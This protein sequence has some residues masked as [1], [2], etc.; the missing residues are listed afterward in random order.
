MCT[1]CR[2]VPGETVSI[3]KG[4][5]ASIQHVQSNSWAMAQRLVLSEAVKKELKYVL[6]NFLVFHMERRLRAAKYLS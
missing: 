5:V 4:A 3:S 6:N 2:E 1:A